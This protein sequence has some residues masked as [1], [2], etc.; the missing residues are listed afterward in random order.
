M[1][2]TKEARLQVSRVNQSTHMSVRYAVV[3]P[4][5]YDMQPRRNKLQ[6]ISMDLFPLVHYAV[7]FILSYG[8]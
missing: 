2:V 3:F 1:V 7:V 5:L 4:N 8:C 6:Q